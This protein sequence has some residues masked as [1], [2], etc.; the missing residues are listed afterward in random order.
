MKKKIIL[1][2]LIIFI[3]LIVLFF[4]F[5]SKFYVENYNENITLNVNEEYNNDIKVCFKNKFK[6]VDII[7]TVSGSVD[8]SKI[9]VYTINYLYEYKNKVLEKTVNINVVDNIE[10]T[11]ELLD[12]TY[13][14]CPNNKL[15]EY[16]VKAYD[17]IDGDITDKLQTSILNDKI[18]F[19]VEDSQGNL[20][21]KEV[22]GTIKDEK[23][24][25]TLNGDSVIYIEQNSKYNELGANALDYCDGALDVKISGSVDTSKIGEYKITYSVTDKYNN[26]SSL[27]RTIYVYPVSNYSTP[28]GKTIYLTFDDGPSKYTSQLLDI[29]KKY[30]V[31]ATFFVT[32]QSFTQGYDDVIKRAYNEGHTIALHSKSHLYS[33]IYTSLDAYFND[34]YAIQAKVKNITGYT[35]Y[36]VRLPGGSS[37]TVSKKYDGG[38]KIMSQI[39]KQLEIKGFRY[40]DWNVVSGDAGETTSTDKIYSNVI[41]QLGNNSTYVVLQHDTKKYSIDAVEK[42]IKYG[43]SNGYTFSNITMESP[44]VHQKIN[45]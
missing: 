28:T 4:I 5:N 37:N 25:I 29:L 21:V 34:L 7:P 6:C 22:S 27:S 39:T 45:N 40:F 20:A 31:K 33:D 24:N 35:S 19:S 30:N 2:I 8:T 12:D 44:T 9:G 14:Y 13:Y 38:I 15:Y 10:P 41:S 32:D 11:I 23:P 1:S 18:I 43:L 3:I 26:T 16:N 17:N 36:I 42:I